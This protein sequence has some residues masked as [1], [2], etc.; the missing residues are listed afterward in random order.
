MLT[1]EEYEY[2]NGFRQALNLFVTHG[3]YVGGCD[4][5]FDWHDNR[6]AEGT[7]LIDR[8]CP[9]CKAGFLKLT[10]SLLIQYEKQNGIG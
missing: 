5:V 9:G 6:R 7:P 1:K 3:E 10:H 4:A 8:G 2:L